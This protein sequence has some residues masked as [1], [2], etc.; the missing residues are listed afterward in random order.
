MEYIFKINLIKNALD[1][2]FQLFLVCSFK[3]IIVIILLIKKLYVICIVYYVYTLP[4]HA[5]MQQLKPCAARFDKLLALLMFVVGEIKFVLFNQIQ[6][7]MGV[8][9]QSGCKYLRCFKLK[10]VFNI[11]TMNKN[12][13]NS[14]GR[15]LSII[16][17]YLRL[18]T[19]S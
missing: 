15:K 2:L 10:I 7:C 5:F 1:N 17:L 6:I 12:R 9:L 3:N 19:G 18:R 4:M 8:L 16:I 14:M 11:N 13:H